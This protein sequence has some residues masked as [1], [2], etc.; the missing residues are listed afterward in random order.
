MNYYSTNG[1]SSKSSFKDVLLQGLA[2]DK[3]LFMPESVP[4]FS[5][6]EIFGFK[7]KKYYEIAFE[8]ISKF[9]ADEI[10]AAELETIVKDA[11]N[12]SVP[13]E[14]IKGFP[15]EAYVLRLD[16]GPTASFKD[17]AARAMARLMNYFMREDARKLTILVATSGDTGSAVANAFYGLDNIEVIVLFPEKEVTP[18]QRKQ[19]TTLGKNVFV[20][21]VKGKFDDC[22]AMVK[23]AFVDPDL[24]TLYNFSSAN[25][26]NLG[27]LI[28]QAVYYF[29][30]YS[31]VATAPGEEVVFSVP[32]GNF[33]DLCGGLIAQRMGLPVKRFVVAVNENDEFS[34]FVET[35]KYEKI[36]PSKGCISNAMNVGHPSNLSRLI[37]LYTGKMDE[38]GNIEKLPNMEKLRKEIFAVSVSDS[39]TRE[40]IINAYKN[41][42]LLLEPHG[43]VAW[44]GLEVFLEKED[45][46]PGEK[47]VS[48]ETA[49]PSKFPEEIESLLNMKPSLHPALMEVANKKEEYGLI[50]NDYNSFKEF[51]K[52][53]KE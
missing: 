17:F 12:F 36:V 15:H 27:R 6:K 28:P 53:R 9:L 29:Y 2:E 8:V 48:L 52:K 37:D 38:N 19:M 20:L 4:Q 34:K 46:F 21:A 24:N 47:F 51:L 5:Q 31:R 39:E 33:G 49:H 40:A 13:L 18:N 11:Y 44:K 23:R 22:Q 30:A 42:M 7:E 25:S 14:K 45:T 32:S 43:A 35:G 26:I 16:G 1:I 3:G 50:E 41:Y 10:P